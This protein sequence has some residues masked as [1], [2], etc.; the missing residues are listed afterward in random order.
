MKTITEQ[1][2]EDLRRIR[3]EINLS[4]EKLADVEI[5]IKRLKSF[6]EDIF[7]KIK[8]TYKD[9]SDQ[10]NKLVEVYGNVSID[11]QTGEI[12]DSENI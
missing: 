12:K 5:E 7:S 8:T 4:K 10:Q 2:L 9:F 11:L 6:K 1:E 3:L